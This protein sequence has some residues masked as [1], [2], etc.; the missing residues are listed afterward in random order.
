[1]LDPAEGQRIGIAQLATAVVH[2][3]RANAPVIRRDDHA[4]VEH[5]VKAICTPSKSQAFDLEV[6]TN[7]SLTFDCAL[8]HVI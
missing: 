1:V 2:F 8:M 4:V 7:P 3:A 6:R 5:I